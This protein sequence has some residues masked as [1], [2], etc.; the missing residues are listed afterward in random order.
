MKN[1]GELEYIIR[2]FSEFQ[3]DEKKGER[4]FGGFV[5]YVSDLPDLEK[6]QF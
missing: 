1:A 6:T 4:T 5:K 2:L 3:I